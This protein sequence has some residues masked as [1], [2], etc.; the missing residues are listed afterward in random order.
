MGGNDTLNGLGGV[1]TLIGGTGND[2]GTYVVDTTTD[3]ITEIASGGNDTVLSSTTFT[4]AAQL[5]NL[6]LTGV[7]AINGTG[8]TV[9]N[10][11]TG[12][13]NKQIFS[14]AWVAMIA[15]AVWAAWIRR[16]AAQVTISM[17]WIPQPISLLNLLLVVMIRCRVQ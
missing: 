15:N 12:N 13:S 16:L 3:T 10:I 14:T 9:V 6:T 1:D 4:L 8:N 17:W 7:A 5:E 2:K 11:L